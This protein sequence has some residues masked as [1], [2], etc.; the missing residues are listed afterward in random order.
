VG[1]SILLGDLW[2]EITAVGGVTS[3][4]IGSAY[5]GTS[6]SGENYAIA[7][8]V[9]GVSLAKLTLQ[10]STAPLVSFSYVNTFTLDSV[11]LLQGQ[12]GIS[13]TYGS[14][15][16]LLNLYC[17]GCGIGLSMTLVPLTTLFN[18]LISNTTTGAAIAYD[19]V[20][21]SVIIAMSTQSTASDA[22]QL[23]SCSN[24]GL[25]NNSFRVMTGSGI[26]FISGNTALNVTGTLIEG[27]T[28]DGIKLT[29]TSDQIQIAVNT[30]KNNTGYGINIAASTC[31]NNIVGL[32]FLGS[33]TAGNVNDSGTTTK[34]RSNIGVADN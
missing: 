27:A 24:I 28:G 3:L 7:T 14:F 1:R 17:N 25:E 15:V 32:N 6:L 12:Y 2:Y 8:T 30:I 10:N 23:T 31:D 20:R 16:N 13:G 18:G 26:N 9:D 29:A 22:V 5:T 21:N 33:N 4:T 11:N 19:T 34:I